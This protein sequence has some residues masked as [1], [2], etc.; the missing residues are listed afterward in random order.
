MLKLNSNMEIFRNIVVLLSGAFIYLSVF[1]FSGQIIP[2]ETLKNMYWF[3]FSTVAIT[4]F[5]IT[6]AVNRFLFRLC[7]I[8]AGIFAFLSF[9]LLVS[10][11][12]VLR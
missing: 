3:A 7:V 10:A 11:L 8:R 1:I 12:F 5:I 4:G 2:E 6:F 9:I